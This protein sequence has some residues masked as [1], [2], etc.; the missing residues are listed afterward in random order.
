MVPLLKLSFAAGQCHA[1]VLEGSKLAK[2]NS[3][4]PGRDA[5]VSWFVEICNAVNNIPDGP[6]PKVRGRFSGSGSVGVVLSLFVA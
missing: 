5:R 1:P 3:T 2:L 4:V 6:D